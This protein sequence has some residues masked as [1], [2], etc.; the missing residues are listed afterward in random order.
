MELLASLDRFAPERGFG[1]VP[2][3]V[4][5]TYAPRVYADA[6]SH[7][8]LALAGDRV[9]SGPTELTFPADAVSGAWRRWLAEQYLPHRLLA[10][11]PAGEL[12]P[13]PT[14]DLA[15]WLDS[16]ALD[17]V[18]P[19]WPGDS[20]DEFGTSLRRGGDCSGPLSDP[21]SADEWLDG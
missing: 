18:S 13:R 16:L 17:E 21:T 8:S 5:D 10:P 2:E 4:L 15:A 3:R 19:I 7:H 1:E 6:L 14:G 11:R 20:S 12:A 9:R